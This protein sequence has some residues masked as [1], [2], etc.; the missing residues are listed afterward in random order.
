LNRVS[1][2][3]L[4]GE[5]R[6]WLGLIVVG[7]ALAPAVAGFTLDIAYAL[8]AVLVAVTVILLPV[9]VYLFARFGP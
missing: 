6:M 9:L 1:E 3:F 7:L 5:L 2:T 4:R 8:R